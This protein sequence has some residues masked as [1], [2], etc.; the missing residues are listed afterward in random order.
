MTD[1]TAW[2]VI[3]LNATGHMSGPMFGATGIRWSAT[4][5]AECRKRDHP[6]PR[7]GCTCGIYAT[8]TREA[9]APVVESTTELIGAAATVPGTTG[10]YP[11]VIASATD[12]MP[13]LIDPRTAVVVLEGTLHD[14][15]PR[16]Q[17]P[18]LE[19]APVTVRMLMPPLARIRATVAGIDVDRTV[20]HGPKEGTEPVG[21]WRG[22]RFTAHTVHAVNAPAWLTDLVSPLPVI[23]HPNPQSLTTPSEVNA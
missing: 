8:D 1:L 17:A 15:L 10:R 5:E 6:A 16:T 11:H 9:L 4:F 7:L 3:L 19:L 12:G 23:S 13:V 20:W 22:S 2:R 18:V 14:A 21:T